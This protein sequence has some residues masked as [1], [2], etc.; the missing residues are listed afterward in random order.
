MMLLIILLPQ[1]QQRK[2]VGAVRDPMRSMQQQG[3]TV[4]LGPAARA[5]VLWCETPQNKGT[6][7][8][9]EIRGIQNTMARRSD[10]LRASDQS[11]VWQDG[12]KQECALSVMEQKIN[13][14]SNTSLCRG[15]TA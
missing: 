5:S 11:L 8:S 13:D 10:L 6:A 2:E 7:T 15:L 4:K 3:M 12:S 14:A 1:A 9:M